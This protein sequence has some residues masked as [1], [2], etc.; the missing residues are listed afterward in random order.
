MNFFFHNLYISEITA[1]NTGVMNIPP[2]STQLQ[3][4]IKPQTV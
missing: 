2:T 1:M 3:K 4:N